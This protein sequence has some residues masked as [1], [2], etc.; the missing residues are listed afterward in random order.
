ML[1][2]LFLLFCIFIVNLTYAEWLNKSF[3][4]NNLTREYRVY[5]P[6][7]YDETKVYK[8]VVGVHGLGSNMT[9]FSAAFYNFCKIADTAD[10]ILVFPQGYDKFFLGRG[11]NAGAGTLGQY[12]SAGI[13]DKGFINA[14]TDSIQANYPIDK[15]RTYLFG[16]SNGGFM[17]QRMACESNEKFAAIASIAGT[18]GNKITHCNPGRFLPILHFHGTSDLNV[19]Y[20][21]TLFG[22]NVE[23]MLSVWKKN[24]QCSNQSPLRTDIPN[25]K[26]D[27][28]TVEHYVYQNCK[29]P[30][31]LFKVNNA[32]HILLNQENNDIDYSVEMW[33]FFSPHTLNETEVISANH[34]FKMKE[35]IKIFPNPVRNLLTIDIATSEFQN[36][37]EIN[38][39]DINGKQVLTIDSN[40]NQVH[41]IDCSKWSNGTYFIKISDDTNF[42]ITKFNVIH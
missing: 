22:L 12:P 32:E 15:N 38:I 11:W 37:I 14:V 19:G 17:V 29:Q 40:S 20:Y 1:K 36:N 33:K 39:L 7:N 42:S 2:K 13:D 3:K 27:G 34:Q 8:L 23:D 9:D 6:D 18:I 31:E 26:N 24:N 21:I 41:Q 35:S 5:L 30:V 10:I 28:L 4:H 16:F 25:V